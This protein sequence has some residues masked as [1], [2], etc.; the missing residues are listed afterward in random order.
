ML[1]VSSKVNY[2]ISELRK[3]KSLDMS[4]Y[5]Q[6]WFTCSTIAFVALFSCSW[7][8][9]V[10]AHFVSSCSNLMKTFQTI[11]K[12]NFWNLTMHVRPVR[13]A[14][15]SFQV[16]KQSLLIQNGSQNV[17]CDLCIEREVLR[18]SRE[19]EWI[20]FTL[21]ILQQVKKWIPVLVS[22]QHTLTQFPQQFIGC[23]SICDLFYPSGHSYIITLILR[24]YA[25]QPKRANLSSP[26]APSS[27]F[28]SL[29]LCW[30]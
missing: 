24:N 22:W 6:I 26:I 23:G 15:E 1:L 13:N 12:L 16:D 8:E 25:Q 3:T 20:G 7:S 29:P 4:R 27:P 2:V 5:N 30:L 19:V 17:W 18:F 14:S 21:G 28:P 10:R 9:I 11:F